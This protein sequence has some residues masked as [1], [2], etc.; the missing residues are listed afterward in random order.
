MSDGY[1]P[2][3]ALFQNERKQK[4]NHPDYNGSLELGHEVIQDLMD[5]A[6]L[7]YDQDAGKTTP[8][9]NEEE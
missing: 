2:S 8:P 5:L 4:P 9:P 3:G 6:E 7:D 1:K